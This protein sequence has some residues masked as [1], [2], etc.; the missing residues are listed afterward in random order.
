MKHFNKKIKCALL[1]LLV[2]LVVFVGFSK[3]GILFSQSTSD[4]ITVSTTKKTFDPNNYVASVARVNN[5]IEEKETP[6][7]TTVNVTT[8][9]TVVTTTE[10]KVTTTTVTT[11]QGFNWS[12]AVLSKSKGAVTG[13]SGKETYYNLNMTSVVN[14]MR[15]AG[16]SEEEY[17]YWVREDG[18]KMLGNYVMVAANYEIRPKGTIIESSLGYAI[19]CDTGGFAKK[20]P[21]QIDVAVTWR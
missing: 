18:V 16:Y 9:T 21:T 13:P 4:V 6:E 17:P 12:G 3:A 1:V 15:R 8:K 2:C 11:T 20:N 19:V 14:A 7:T 10:V 5:N